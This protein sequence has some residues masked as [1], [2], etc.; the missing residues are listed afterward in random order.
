MKPD[1]C[2]RANV[3]SPNHPASGNTEEGAKKIRVF[4]DA[5]V[6]QK[7][8]MQIGSFVLDSTIRDPNHAGREGLYTVSERDAKLV[9]A[10]LRGK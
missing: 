2:N 1:H 5:H 9:E 6:G 7:V 3:G 10:G 8:R 4:T